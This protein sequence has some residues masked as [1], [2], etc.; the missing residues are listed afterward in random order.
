MLSLDVPTGLSA[1]VQYWN[2]LF[3]KDRLRFKFDAP[4]DTKIKILA[5]L[6]HIFY[7][8]A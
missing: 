8:S 5:E 6:M 1:D 2:Q 4:E 3:L 7:L